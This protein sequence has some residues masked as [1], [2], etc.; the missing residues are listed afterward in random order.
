MSFEKPFREDS[1]P[2][3]RP[4]PGSLENLRFQEREYPCSNITVAV[5]WRNA[6]DGVG[7]SFRHPGFAHAFIQEV[8]APF[9]KSTDREAWVE[10]EPGF[11]FGPRLF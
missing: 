7:S 2:F 10:R 1:S 3:R 8:A 11:G 5:R 9:A 6:I 4:Y